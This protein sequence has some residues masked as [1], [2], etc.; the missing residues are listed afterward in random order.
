MPADCEQHVQEAVKLFVIVY[1]NDILI[2]SKTLKEHTVHGRKVLVHL[3]ELGL[4][5]KAE[6]CHFHHWWE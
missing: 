4:F 5:V 3:L 2:S 1:I 6:Q